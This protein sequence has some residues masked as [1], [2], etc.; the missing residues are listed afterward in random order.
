MKLIR[1]FVPEITSNDT[2]MPV[3]L[4]LLTWASLLFNY[5]LRCRWWKY[6]NFT[7]S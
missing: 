6:M 7:M 2:L 3:N 4:M 1:Q 5:T